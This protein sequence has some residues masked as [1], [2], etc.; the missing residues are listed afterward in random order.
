VSVDIDTSP[1]PLTRRPANCVDTSSPPWLAGNPTRAGL[2][3]PPVRDCGKTRAGLRTLPNSYSVYSIERLWI[4]PRLLI[5]MIGASIDSGSRPSWWE[6]WRAGGGLRGI[7]GGSHLSEG[8]FPM[9]GYR[10]HAG[11]PGPVSKSRWP[12]GSSVAGSGPRI[13]GGQKGS[14]RACTS[15][16][17][18][19]DGLASG[20]ASQVALRRSGAGMQDGDLNPGSPGAG[21][22]AGPSASIWP[23]PLG[24]VAPGLPA[25]GAIIAGCGSLLALG[26]LGTIGRFRAGVGRL[27]RVR[28]LPILSLPRPGNLGGSGVGL[29]G[30]T[31][32]PV[33]GRD[34]P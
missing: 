27:G 34:D 2:R 18:R 5:S 30:P 25:P 21:R 17:I 3:C 10:R 23:G 33:S 20:R 24:L 26:G 7:V 28:P 29:R 11:S 12:A 4:L 32:G 6:T 22:R 14:P 15:P 19:F 1:R 31:A 16:T 13:V 8:R 9:P